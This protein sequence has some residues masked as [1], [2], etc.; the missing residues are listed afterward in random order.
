ML[1]GHM[2]IKT[3]ELKMSRCLHPHPLFEFGLE[4]RVKDTRRSVCLLAGLRL[5]RESSLTR[6]VATPP[7]FTPCRCHNPSPRPWQL[8]TTHVRYLTVLQ[9]RRPVFLGLWAK[10]L[11]SWV[12]TGGAG[13]NLLLGLLGALADPAVVAGP[14]SPFPCWLSA[15]PP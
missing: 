3:Q 13:M 11:A 8:K 14:M 12:L 5:Q 10:V 6:A 15:G 4:R 9:V 7:P 1:K 2:M